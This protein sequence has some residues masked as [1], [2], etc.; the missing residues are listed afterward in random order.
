LQNT[1]D[2]SP[3][4]EKGCDGWSNCAHQLP[5]RIHVD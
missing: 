5:G 4:I 3:V 2:G 1:A